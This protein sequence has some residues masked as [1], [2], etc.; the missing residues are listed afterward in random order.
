MSNKSLASI[1]FRFVLIIGIVSLFADMTYE[2]A[3]SINGAFLGSLGATGTIVGFVAGIGEL[4]GYGFRSITGFFADKTHKYWTFAFI[5]YVINLFAVPA[6]ALAGN[7]PTAAALMIAERTGRALRKPSMDAM[8]SYAGKSLG[9]GWVFGLHEAL[10]QLGATFGPLIVSLVLFLHGGYKNGYAVLLIAAFLSLL[11]LIIAR[12]LYPKPHE[13]ETRRAQIIKT[14]GF[15]KAFWLYCIAGAFVAAGFVDFSL[16]AFHFQK[17]HIISGQIIPLFY[18]VAMAVGA[19]TALIFGKLY[20]KR[21]ITVVLIA[22]FFS[23][24]FAP[25]VFLG[26]FWVAFIGMILWGL[27]M[28]AQDSMLKALITPVIAVDKRS[29]AFGLFDTVFGVA[30]FVGSA[31]MGFLYDV[32]IPVLIGVSVILQLLALPVFLYAKKVGHK[33]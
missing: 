6:L 25:F 1:A 27:G 10:D 21:G 14:K 24:L 32:S 23:S 22:F 29:T 28:G 19:I 7:W 17:T 20:D 33:G 13:L 3:R 26:T 8:L 31:A 16:V 30:W 4:I 18:A 12:L 15:S 2:G 11:V 9:N 5:G